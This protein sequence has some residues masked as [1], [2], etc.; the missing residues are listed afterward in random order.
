MSRG[1]GPAGLYPSP[2]P[3]GN[4]GLGDSA[5]TQGETPCT[6]ERTCAH[7]SVSARV[8]TRVC[9]FGVGLL[10]SFAERVVWYLARDP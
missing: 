7:V 6:C 5:E 9:A 1:S 2:H 8:H 10:H 4:A 3:Q